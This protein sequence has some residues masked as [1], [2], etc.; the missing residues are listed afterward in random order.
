MSLDTPVSVRSKS[1]EP[2]P[3]AGQGVTVSLGQGAVTVSGA[4]SIAGQQMTRLTDAQVLE[5]L[6]T[7]LDQ[8]DWSR[9]AS[10]LATRLNGLLSCHRVAVGWVTGQTLHLKVLSDG[11]LLDEGAAIPEVHQA[12]LEAA[13]QQT[14]LSWP[15]NSDLP[16]KD[17][18]ITLAHQTLLRV[19][20]LA[21]VTSLPLAV[22]GKVVGAITLERSHIDILDPAKL[23]RWVDADATEDEGRS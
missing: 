21:G 9:G 4:S 13:H 19:Q 14:M 6:K 2:Q 18:F 15:L 5:C 7:F 22:N 1:A 23:A 17:Q 3:E 8:R 16:A 11:V 20:G 10:E 12:M